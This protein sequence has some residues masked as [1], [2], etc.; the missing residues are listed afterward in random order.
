MNR[1][2]MCVLI[3]V[4]FLTI[5]WGLPA[6]AQCPCSIWA[7]GAIPGAADGGDGAAGEYG[8]KI[9]SDV[10][11]FITGVRFYK[12]VANTG[13]HIGNLWSDTG[14]LLASASFMGESA[15]GW[16]QVNFSSAVPITA[17]T[18][19]VASYYTSAGHY[20][21]D[22]NYFGSAATDNP[23]L[24]ALA[25][26]TDGPNAVYSY[27]PASAF[28][29]STYNSSNYWVD[30]VFNT[31][32]AP[33]VTS[34][35]PIGTGVSVASAISATFSSQLDPTTVNTSSVQLL[36]GSGSPV[37]ISLTYNASTNVVTAQPAA[38]LMAST[39][40]TVV[41]EGGPLGVKDASGNP[42]AANFTWQFATATPPPPT[43][44]CPCS[45][46]PLSSVPGAID[47][48]D[49]NPGEYGVKFRADVDGSIIAIRF[50]KGANNTGTHIAHLWTSTG[51]LLA[52]A[53]STAES[54]S[55]WQ[56]VSFSAPVFI[57]A[58][59][60][61]V[62]SYYAPSG[63]YSFD[64]AY[65]QNGLDT[66]PMHAIANTVSPNGVYS[67]AASSTFPVNSFNASNYWVDAVFMAANSVGQPAVSFTAPKA[68]ATGVSI[69]SPASA[70]FNEPMNASSFN[71]SSVLLLDSSGNPVPGSVSF[72]SA[73]ATVTFTASIELS[74]FTTYTA[75]IKGTV[76]DSFGNALGSDYTWSFTTGGPPSGSGPGGPVLVISSLANPYS[77]YYD[78]ILRAEGLNEF[79]VQDIAGI[80][81]SILSFYHVAIL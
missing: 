50:Y 58:G 15:S 56:Q 60:T 10:N 48:G 77:N 39:T 34:S 72:D 36:D 62:A 8:I 66:P 32:N 61:Y 71:S 6:T 80:N 33:Y 31:V 25:N 40:Y 59:T 54:S 57:S 28:P 44:V 38:S 20:S 67:Y 49:S 41:I 12:S 24:H 68:Q 73:T 42:M 19:Y 78:E 5:V 35:S 9:R 52:T 75:T 27:G 30:V 16:Q 79:S 4:F 21:F 13:L 81:A 74:V 3:A 43:P 11:G 22:P 64:A 63:H 14:T 70:T 7:P 53:T 2:N 47:S 69:G 18:T 17:G 46:W 29:V 51:Q 37:S 23:P 76:K 55:G 26:G 1:Q 45:I 65:L